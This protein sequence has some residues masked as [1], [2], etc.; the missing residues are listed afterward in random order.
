MAN[1]QATVQDCKDLGG[2]VDSSRFPNNNQLIT[3]ADVL[4]LGVNTLETDKADNQ[5]IAVNSLYSGTVITPVKNYLNYVIMVYGVVPQW[6]SIIL[7][8]NTNFPDST[9]EIDALPYQQFK[10][11]LYFNKDMVGRAITITASVSGHT[12]GKDPVIR[13]VGGSKTYTVGGN[14]SIEINPPEL[15]P[16]PEV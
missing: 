15:T 6:K 9:V 4:Y 13:I 16:D 10:D 1:R 14:I 3:K 12:M 7:T 11:K 2:I 8:F 5:T